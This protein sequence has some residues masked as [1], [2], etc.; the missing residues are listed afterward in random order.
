MDIQIDL[1]GNGIVIKWDMLKWEEMEGSYG[2]YVSIENH[3]NEGMGNYDMILFSFNGYGYKHELYKSFKGSWIVDF[4]LF[5]S[6]IQ[7]ILNRSKY[8]NEDIINLIKEWI[9]KEL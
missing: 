6:G 9:K 7:H 2:P 8:T 4:S 3:W 5:I 1:H